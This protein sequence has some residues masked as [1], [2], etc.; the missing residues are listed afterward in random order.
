MFSIKT[1]QYIYTFYINESEEIKTLNEMLQEAEGISDTSRAQEYHIPLEIAQKCQKD[2]PPKELIDFVHNAYLSRQKEL[3]EALDFYN[4]YWTGEGQKHLEKIAQIMDQKIP[5][6][7]VRLDL[8]CSGTSDWFGTNIS[9]HAFDYKL[10]SSA[11]YATLLW[12]TILALTFHQIRSKYPKEDLPD[13]IVWAIS[14]MTSCAIINCDF[15]VI[16]KMGYTQLFPHQE[17]IMTLYKSKQ[18]FSDFLEK[19]ITYLRPLK[20]QITI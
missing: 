11:W 16:W 2:F 8:F 15:P 19:M 18:N 4:H 5:P 14:E 9:I 7:R 1:M 17:N 13:N 20:N 6:F 3:E 12:E 10:N